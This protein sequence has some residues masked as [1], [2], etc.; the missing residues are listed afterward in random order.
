MV[1][2]LTWQTNHDLDLGVQLPNGDYV[3]F[4][5]PSQAGIYRI[6]SSGNEHCSD[7]TAPATE[8]II[9]AENAAE[10]ATYFAF[11]QQSFKCNA[12][13]DVASFTLE[14]IIDGEVVKSIQGTV[15]GE[16]NVVESY[17]FTE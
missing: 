8:E 16:N 17:T 5:N 15:E 9:F 12:T 3:G 4:M 13:E 7:V 14:F 11:V 1:I 10:S 6:A 2:R